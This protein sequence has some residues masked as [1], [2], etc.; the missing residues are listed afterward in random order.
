MTALFTNNGQAELALGVLDMLVS[1][2]T[3]NM[4]F[5]MMLILD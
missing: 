2:A 4:N 5:L 3:T 1:V